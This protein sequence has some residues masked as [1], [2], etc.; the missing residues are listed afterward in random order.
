MGTAGEFLSSAGG[1]EY[2]D[3]FLRGLGD[4][5]DARC[6]LLL[7]PKAE[8]ASM[9]MC[10]AKLGILAWLAAASGGEVV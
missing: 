8:A 1:G 7:P 3:N 5:E 4:G 6:E 9:L 10:L 2:R